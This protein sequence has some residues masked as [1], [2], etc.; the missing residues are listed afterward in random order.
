MKKKVV[1]ERRKLVGLTQLNLMVAE[2]RK[3]VGLTQLNLMV[4]GNVK[5]PLEVSNGL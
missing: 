3:L 1:A 4:A 5:N 2:R